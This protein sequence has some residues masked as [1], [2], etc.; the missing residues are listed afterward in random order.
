MTDR[1]ALLEQLYAALKVW[2]ADPSNVNWQPVQKA[3][4]AL[5]QGG[6]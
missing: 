6:E 5:K 3:I 1:T 4:N 2:V